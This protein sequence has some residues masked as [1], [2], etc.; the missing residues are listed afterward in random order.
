[1]E[2]REREKERLRARLAAVV[3]EHG[4]D[5]VQT[6]LLRKSSLQPNT[7]CQLEGFTI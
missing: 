1:M 6:K 2:V 3:E 7:N 4:L 5:V